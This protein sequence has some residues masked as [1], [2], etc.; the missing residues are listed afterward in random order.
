MVGTGY[1]SKFHA[2]ILID[3]HG[4][5][6]AA[7]CGTSSEKA[8]SMAAEF[9][10]A[11]GYANLIEMLDEAHLDAV[12]ICVPPMMHGEIELALI[13]R[14]IHFLVEKPLGNELEVPKKILSEIKK[15]SLITSVGYQHRYS[16]SITR[17]KRELSEQ[18]IG[19]VLGQFSGSISPVSWWKD[20]SSS[21]GQFLEQTTHIVDLL[22]FFCGEIED[23]HAVYAGNIL[24]TKDSSVTVADVGTVTLKLKSGTIANISNTCILPATIGKAGLALYTEKGLYEWTPGRLEI[25]TIEGK[26]EV[27]DDA[28]PYRTESEAFMHAVRTGDRSKILSDYEDAFKTHQVTCAALASAETSI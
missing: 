18:N 10:G 14:S 4:V 16:D 19:M 12:Y 8:S 26:S 6:I 22:R 28:N 20:Q 23:V 1:F 11:K 25:T 15:K 17:L 2:E 13:N 24:S 7:I 27:Q 3:I 21:G 5:N 9:P